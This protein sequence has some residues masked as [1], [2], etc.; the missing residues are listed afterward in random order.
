MS[1]PK[2]LRHILRKNDFATASF[3]PALRHS[4]RLILL[5]PDL[6]RDDLDFKP[7][8][9]QEERGYGAV[10]SAAH[11]EDDSGPCHGSTLRTSTLRTSTP[12]LE[13]YPDGWPSHGHSRGRQTCPPPTC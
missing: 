3:L 7:L 2:S 13:P 12:E 11:S 8:F 10:N 4:D 1:D 5:L 6:E 9:N